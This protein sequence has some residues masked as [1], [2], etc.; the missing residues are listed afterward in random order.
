M[1]RLTGKVALVVGGARGIGRAV[2][3]AFVAEGAVVYVGDLEPLEPGMEP[4]GTVTARRCEA[5]DPDQ[6]RQLV[7]ETMEAAGRV[8]ILVNNVGMHLPVS[9][10]D[11]TPD[12]FDRVFA[13]NV[14]PAYLA[15]HFLLPHLLQRGAGSIV[16]VSSNG[17]LV[18][19]PADPLYNASK[20]AL[21]GLT[22][23][24]ALAYAQQGVRVNAVCP[25]PVDT[26]MMRGAL[27]E[28]E[29]DAMV[30]QFVASTPA[31]R[32]A[33]PDE[34]AAAVVFLA[35][36]ESPAVTG[37]ALPVDGGKSAGVLT[38]DRYRPD[39]ELNRR[40]DR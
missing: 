25:G 23:S 9:V 35:S 4:P 7:E 6:V 27:S 38:A 34:V 21:I 3:A 24:L 39:P 11:A 32:I 1:N 20:H 29:F 33:D 10:I 5:S 22:K 31:A 15:C 13:V 14:K 19:R 16:N 26:K 18:G 40:F 17:G 8:D 12:D 36:D 2:V 30:P 28:Q 37:A